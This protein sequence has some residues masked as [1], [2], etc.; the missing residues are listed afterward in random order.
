MPVTG[1]AAGVRHAIGMTGQFAAVDSLLTGEEDLRLMERSL[2]PGG[3]RGRADD[4]RLLLDLFLRPHRRGQQ[5]G[6]HVFG[7][8]APPPSTWP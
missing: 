4:R 5:G 7:W 8:D 3:C 2:P 6:V 1:D